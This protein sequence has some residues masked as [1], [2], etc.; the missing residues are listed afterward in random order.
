M[1]NRKQ[2]FKKATLKAGHTYHAPGSRCQGSAKVAS[3]HW[4]P[5]LTLEDQSLMVTEAL[6]EGMALP[7]KEGISRDVKTL[8]DP[9]TLYLNG[10][11]E[12]EMRLLH[13]EKMVH[14]WNTCIREHASRVGNTCGI[15]EFAVNHERQK[16]LCWIQALKCTNCG[17]A[18][19][20]LI[21][22]KEVESKGRGPK[23]PRPNMGLQTGLQ[24]CPMGNTKARLLLANTNTP[25]PSL[26]AL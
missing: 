26:S 21:L 10:T 23:P 17:Y 24:E 18:S 19:H 2:W 11:A 3:S 1:S 5:R 7:D 9:T 6:G 20:K 14:M 8:A 15:P 22:N 4:V 16:G 25:P 13:K 12:G